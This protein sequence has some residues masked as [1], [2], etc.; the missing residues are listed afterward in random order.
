[1][2]WQ[3]GLA[4]IHLAATWMMVGVI[5]FVQLVH[6]PMLGLYPRDGF[7]AFAEEHQRRTSWVVIPPMLVELAAALLLLVRSL[8]ASAEGHTRLLTGLGLGLLVAVWASTFLLQVPCH[9]RLLEGKDEATLRRLVATNWLRTVGWTARGLL[10][11]ALLA[12]VSTD[13]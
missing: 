8:T 3:S 6:Y 11:I 2:D 12:S 5:W 4:T 1:M 10:A 7:V 13:S 9:R